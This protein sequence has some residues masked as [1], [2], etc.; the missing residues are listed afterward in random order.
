MWSLECGEEKSTRGKR[1]LKRRV[2][3]T[4]VGQTSTWLSTTTTFY[5]NRESAPDTKDRIRTEDDRQTKI[6]LKAVWTNELEMTLRES[7]QVTSFFIR[8]RIHEDTLRFK[9]KFGGSFHKWGHL[10]LC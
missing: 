8:Q 1:T 5:P 2:V 7:S 6:S 10:P 4:V 3:R 9:V